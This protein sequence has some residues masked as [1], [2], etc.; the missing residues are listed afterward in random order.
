MMV[1]CADMKTISSFVN[2]LIDVPYLGEEEEKRNV[3]EG[4]LGYD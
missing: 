2:D 4:T 3:C 1:E